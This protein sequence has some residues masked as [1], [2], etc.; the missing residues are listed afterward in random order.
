MKKAKLEKSPWVK[1]KKKPGPKKVDKSFDKGKKLQLAESDKGSWYNQADFLSNPSTSKD[2][3]ESRMK[4]TASAAEKSEDEQSNSGE[5]DI[6]SESEIEDL[7]TGDDP[8]TF[9][10]VDRLKVNSELQRAAS[11]SHCETDGL[12]LEEKGSCGLGTEWRF[13]C[14]NPK[15]SSHEISRVHFKQHRKLVA[16]TI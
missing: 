7:D 1:V 13:C 14:K 8:A 11:C 2:I 12:T 9:A 10:V 4:I 6:S 15:C 3:G 5:S 16:R